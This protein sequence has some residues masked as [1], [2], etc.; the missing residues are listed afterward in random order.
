M[1]HMPFQKPCSKVL[2][3]LLGIACTVVPLAGCAKALGSGPNAAAVT[4]VTAH[5]STTHATE[6][7]EG[8]VVSD[9]VVAVTAPPLVDDIAA[10]VF[11]EVG[12]HVTAGQ[13]LAIVNSSAESLVLQQNQANLGA[14]ISHLRYVSQPYRPEEIAEARL[15]VDSDAKAV[16]VARERLSIAETGRPEDISIAEADLAGAQSQQDLDQANFD[17]SKKLYDQELLPKSDFDAAKTA[18]DVAKSMTASKLGALKVAETGR[19]EDVRL[20]KDLLE[21]AEIV[22]TKDREQYRLLTSG[23]H[24]DEISEARSLVAA[25]G[26]LVNQNVN[27]I[28]RF[29]VKAPLDGIV[30]ERN[31]NPGEAVRPL[32]ARTDT[33]E[34]LQNNPAGIFEIAD[35]KSLSFRASVD[36]MYFQSVHVGMPVEIQLEALPGKRL[37]G[38]V[39]HVMPDI[40]PLE[41]SFDP[42]TGKPLAPLSFPVWVRI[43]SN[44]DGLVPGQSGFATFSR[45]VTGLTVPS[46]AINALSV[47]EGIIYVVTDGAVHRRKV[48]FQSTPT[49][50][51]LIIQGVSD[52]DKV[53]VSDW[54]ALTEGEAVTPTEQD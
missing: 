40:S 22:E 43:T 24:P 17:R 13:T 53:V 25:D 48:R 50:D 5:R 47:D 45:D 38:V 3:P 34:T 9:H 4:V 31:I 27:L 19:P 16:A 33:V 2:L 7:S 42:K 26:A 46:G 28:Q 21:Q 44:V 23:G 37:E 11:A 39:D 32:D 35:M 18:L 14:A 10:G 54:T 41:N 52:G 49:G 30:V 36:Q 51:A 1:S 29:V 20:A 8:A 15:Q 12:D 6:I